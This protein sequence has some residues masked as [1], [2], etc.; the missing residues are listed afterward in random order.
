ME[1]DGKKILCITDIKIN[2]N[3]D[4]SEKYIETLSKK[5]G[6]FDHVIKDSNSDLL[7]FTTKIIQEKLLPYKENVNVLTCAC[8]AY[9]EL[10]NINMFNLRKVKNNTCI[11]CGCEIKSENIEALISDIK[12]P[13]KEDFLFKHN[14]SKLDFTHFLNR[15]GVKHKISKRNEVIKFSSEFSNFGIRYQFLWAAMIVYLCKKENDNNVTM[16]YVHKVQDKAFY[17]CSLVK[18]MNPDINF[19]LKSIPVVWIEDS[20]IISEC[21]PS[22][23]KLLSK[24]LET[25]RKELKVSLKNWRN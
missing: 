16:H 11:I 18:M 17:V 6:S 1:K 22:H 5:I 2:R 21:L 13:L 24:T 19:Y 8:G 20:P 14:W 23:I 15:Q 4:S 7:N 10:V 3:F 25:K 12:W 9:E